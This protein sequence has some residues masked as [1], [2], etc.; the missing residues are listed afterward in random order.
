MA[1][2]AGILFEGLETCMGAEESYVPY[3]KGS[4]VTG[5]S[6]RLPIDAGGTC[7]LR[8]RNAPEELTC[9]YDE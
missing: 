4:G 2:I 8:E 6:V 5:H 3:G 7:V 9:S 1:E